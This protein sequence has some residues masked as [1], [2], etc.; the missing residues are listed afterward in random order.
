MQRR[1]EVNCRC[2]RRCRVHSCTK[3]LVYKTR[4]EA[5]AFYLWGPFNFISHT[6]TFY[7]YSYSIVCVYIDIPRTSIVPVRHRCSS[8]P[9][10]CGRC[11]WAV[12]GRAIVF[13]SFISRSK[14]LPVTTTTK[15]GK[16]RRKEW[17][18]RRHSAKPD[19]DDIAATSGPIVTGNEPEKTRAEEIRNTKNIYARGSVCVVCVIVYYNNGG[20]ARWLD[21]V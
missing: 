4:S 18:R 13:T 1:R 9:S 11:R 21:N 7:F 10:C 15:T 5:T 14:A 2:R 12:I 6:R 19:D 17:R 20:G 16:V 3:F 8:L